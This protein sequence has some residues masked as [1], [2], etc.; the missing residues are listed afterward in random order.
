VGGDDLEL[1]EFERDVVEQDR[2]AHG[3]RHVLGG[4]AD[5]HDQRQVELDALGIEG[6]VAAMVDLEVEAVGMK[7]GANEVRVAAP[8]VELAHAVQALAGIDPD[9]P[10]DA[11]GRL[12]SD[13]EDLL[14]ADVPDQLLR[15]PGVHLGGGDHHRLHA[16]AV[17]VGDELFGRV[18]LHL[19]ASPLHDV[20][21]LLERHTEA[22]GREHGA[23]VID[24]QSGS[25]AFRPQRF[26]VYHI[27]I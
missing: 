7:V 10:E 5:L 26:D 23:P 15:D 2:P 21:R 1:G 22:F 8:P 19:E 14:L 20:L 27:Q 24:C 12:L 16:G 6:V 11:A 17:H 3:R 18:A 13:L 9:E 4:V 25:P